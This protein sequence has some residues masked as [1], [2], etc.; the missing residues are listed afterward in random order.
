MKF[1]KL[2]LVA[3]SLIGLSSCSSSLKI[4]E[5]AEPKFDLFEYFQGSTKAWG[6]FQDFTGEVKRRFE[7]EITGTI[8]D[9]GNTLTLDEQFIYDDGE[10]DQRVWVIKKSS[11]GKYIGTAGDV[12]GE[13][14]GA[15]SGFALNWQ[16]T[17][18][19]PYKDD[20]INVK[21]DDWMYRLNRDVMVNRAKVKKFGF[22]VGEVT[23]FFQKNSD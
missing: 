11:D 16:Y 4:Y 10:K 3:L 22:T 23:L 2:L 17:L 8:S 18:A 13:A 21:F 20:V 19:L 15:E 14:N 1:S 5:S 6:I 9:Q 12:I 7:V